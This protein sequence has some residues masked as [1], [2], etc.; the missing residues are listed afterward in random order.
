M[1]LKDLFWVKHL[2]S[3]HRFLGGMLSRHLTSRLDQGG[4][5][6][7]GSDGRQKSAFWNWLWL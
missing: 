3:Q 1:W 4:E 6:E 7:V 5:A 2:Q